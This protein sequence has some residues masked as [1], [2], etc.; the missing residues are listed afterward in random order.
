MNRAM[1][2]SDDALH[3]F[4]FAFGD[5]RGPLVRVVRTI[6]GFVMECDPKTIRTLFDHHLHSASLN[7]TATSTVADILCPLWVLFGHQPIYLR[8]R[9]L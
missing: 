9:S 5:A 6:M 2:L 1:N 4:L 3:E 7:Q 8:L